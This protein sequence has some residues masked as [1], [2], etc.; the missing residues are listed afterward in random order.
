MESGQSAK[1]RVIVYIDGFNLY[2]SL[3]DAGLK[4][5]YWLDVVKFS[6]SLLLEHQKLEKVKYFSSHIS[7]PEGKR[8]RQS[9]YFDALK[10]LKKCE[11][12]FGHYRQEKMECRSCRKNGLNILKKRQ[13]LI[14]VFN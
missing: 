13:M 10:T 3:K 9:I 2:Y 7:S 5:L 6:Q 14:F 1:E 11:M 4:K 8:R 12:Y